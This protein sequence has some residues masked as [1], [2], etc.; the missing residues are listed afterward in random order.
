MIDIKTVSISNPQV[1]LNLDGFHDFLGSLCSRSEA[2]GNL[3]PHPTPPSI[4]NMK[5]IGN[6]LV[7]SS[8]LCASEDLKTSPLWMRVNASGKKEISRTASRKIQL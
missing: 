1:I 4:Q 7:H 2:E 3:S 5:K 6:I 8:P